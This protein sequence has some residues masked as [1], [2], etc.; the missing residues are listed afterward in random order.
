MLHE[1]KQLL[2]TTGADKYTIKLNHG[3]H[4]LTS[5]GN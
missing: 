2:Q 5:A 4:Q 3:H 1:Y